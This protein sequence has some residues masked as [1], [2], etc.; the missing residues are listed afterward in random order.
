MRISDWSSDVC[1]SDLHRAQH[2]RNPARRTRRPDPP[3]PRAGGC[4]AAGRLPGGRTVPPRTGP[5]HRANR[6][7][8]GPVT[9]HPT[10]K[11]EITMTR[12]AS[13][14]LAA[15]LLALVLA[16]AL[17]LAA[18]PAGEYRAPFDATARPLLPL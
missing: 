13:I 7:A 8:A 10:G 4:R 6:D 18:P 14:P 12:H 16:S 1:S 9:R 11:K 15:G 3:D 5:R 17:S 2:R